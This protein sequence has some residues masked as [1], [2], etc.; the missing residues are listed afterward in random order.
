MKIET[1]TILQFSLQFQ[2]AQTFVFPSLTICDR[3]GFKNK[4]VM[5][6][7]NMSNFRLMTTK[8][9]AFWPNEANQVEASWDN[10]T[11]QFDELVEKIGIRYNGG[12]YCTMFFNS[13]ASQD[14]FR[15]P[16]K[17]N[18]FDIVTLATIHHGRCYTFEFSQSINF[19]GKY[20]M[21]YMMFIL[22]VNTRPLFI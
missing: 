3:N 5:E 18:L 21:Y 1:I 17:D 2:N 8:P 10:I 7:A 13:N 4:S 16:C 11:F 12:T 19:W 6:S 14:A 22:K 20:C 15:A 9:F